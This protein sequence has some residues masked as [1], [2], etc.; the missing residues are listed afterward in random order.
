LFRRERINETVPR[1]ANVQGK[2]HVFKSRKAGGFT[3][4]EMSVVLVVIG[5]IMGAVSIGK[6]M[7][8]NAEYSK[9]KQKFLDQWV[10][11]YNS[12]YMRAGVVVGD[13]QVEPRMMVNGDA[14]NSGTTVVSGNDMTGATEPA[15]ICAGAAAPKMTRSA[16]VL[17]TLHD[18]M[19]RTGVRMPPGRA[20]GREDRYVYLDSNGNPQEIQVCFQW[21]KPGTPSGSGNVMVISGLTPDLARTLDQMVDGKADAQEG[22]FRQ[23]GVANGTPGVAGVE[24]AANNNFAQADA[25]PSATGAGTK[26]DESQVVTLVAHYKMSQ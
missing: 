23:E 2:K 14:Y 13:K 3:L 25:S 19:D 18:F 20:E 26:L 16:G 24:W 21:N 10:S 11:A 15:A 22:L 7:Q 8:R 5:L 12:Y 9:I 4:I 17:T 6:D 1:E